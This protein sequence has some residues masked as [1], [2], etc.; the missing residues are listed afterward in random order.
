MLLFI[1]GA[2]TGGKHFLPASSTTTLKLAAQVTFIAKRVESCR[3][4][5]GGST[6]PLSR[7]RR[8]KGEG[9]RQITAA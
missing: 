6:P 3:G 2:C 8:P 9:P 5:G 7:G 4:S 1:G